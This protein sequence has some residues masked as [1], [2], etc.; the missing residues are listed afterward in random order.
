MQDEAWRRRRRRQQPRHAWSRGER[1]SGPPHA[2]DSP[3]HRLAARG[4][5]QPR[6][7][8]VGQRVPNC[9]SWALSL[10]P[11]RHLASVSVDGGL[12][13]D[14]R[15]AGSGRLP[16]SL[17]WPSRGAM[18][19]MCRTA[20]TPAGRAVQDAPTGAARSAQAGSG[21]AVQ[22]VPHKCTWPLTQSKPA[23]L[24]TGS[25]CGALSHAL[26]SRLAR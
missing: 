3:V 18:R 1:P 8:L 12:H 9:R 11:W 4:G 20:T 15:E 21:C 7:P 22:A 17:G 14:S 6:L 23:E 5:P 16:A 25:C 19:W 13:R 2:S 24:L 26:L 10:R